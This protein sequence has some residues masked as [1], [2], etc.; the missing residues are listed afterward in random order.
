V[1]FLAV[2]LVLTM[3]AVWS[4]CERAAAPSPPLTIDRL[5]NARY[6]CQFPKSKEALLHDGWYVEEVGPGA[7][8]KLVIR[9]AEEHA[10]GDLNGDGIDDA[11]V[12]LVCDPGC[13]GTFFQ[14]AIVLNQEGKPRHVGGALL[15]DRIKLH[16]VSIDSGQIS[17]ELTRHGPHDLI[18][19]PTEEVRQF[20]R[21]QWDG[22]MGPV[23]EPK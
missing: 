9:M 14:L 5:K 22:V 15:G 8:T 12:V 20:Y 10:F 17:V 21:L 18:C 6:H 11:A 19:C 23:S 16:S 3:A 1:R 2:L 13:G 4:A 7:S